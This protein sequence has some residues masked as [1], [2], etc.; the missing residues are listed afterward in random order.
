MR[1]G[2]RVAAA[3]VVITGVAT[4]LTGRA[5]F[6][7]PQPTPYETNNDANMTSAMAWFELADNPA[8]IIDVLGPPDDK[9]LERRSMLDDI[10]HMDYAFLICYSLYNA[11]LIVFVRHLSTYRFNDLLKLTTFLVLG[12]LLALGMAVGD[13][14]ENGHLL[15]FTKAKT[16]GDISIDAFND[17]W[18]WTRV[19]WGSIAGVCLM[20]SIAYV[21]YFRRIP[22]LLLSVLYA[23]AGISIFLAI[24]IPDAR[25]LIQGYGMNSLIA[26][27]LLSLLHA[28]SVLLFG[29]RPPLGPL[30]MVPPE[31]IST[32]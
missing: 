20:L 24:S 16:I 26:A 1:S 9:G 30:P 19:K 13:W 11:A 31:S 10:D 4:I 7:L 15:E 23:V 32:E 28:T 18:Y 27:W 14:I 17:L 29:V 22:T 6:N 21:A 25:W 3:W 12:L 5:I 2:V 8:E